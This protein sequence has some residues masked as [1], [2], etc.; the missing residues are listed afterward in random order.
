VPA[1]QV[2]AG[3]PAEVIRERHT[4]DRQRDELNHRWLYHGAFQDE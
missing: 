2:V 4:E 3:I 1:N